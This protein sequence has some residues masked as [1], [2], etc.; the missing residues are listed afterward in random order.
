MTGKTHRIGGMLCALGGYTLLESKGLLLQNVSPLVQLAVMYPFAIYGSTASDL[1]HEWESC[2]SKD[3][4][5]FMINKLLHLTSKVRD[6]LG[7]KS[8]LGKILGVFD[9][10]HRSWQTHSDLFLF[11]MIFLS[12][13]L[14]GSDVNSVNSIIIRLIFTGLILGIVSH[15]ILDMLTPEGVWCILTASIRGILSSKFI[16]KRISHLPNKKFIRGVI[17]A[18]PMKVSLVPR[19]KFFATDGV[20]EKL[21]R[22]VMWV[23]CI[24]LFLNI[25]YGMLPYEFYFL[26]G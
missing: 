11:L 7:E 13:K 23:A 2:P 19:S 24:V 9:S 18:I 14:V 4:F 22:Y 17:K 25:I 6:R 10:N 21:V 8:F 20:W 15:L 5:S 12:M 1:D 26:K 3:V 16:N